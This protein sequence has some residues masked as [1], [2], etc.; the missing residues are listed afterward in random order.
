MRFLGEMLQECEIS[1][2]KFIP[3]LKLFQGRQNTV[4]RS[5]PRVASSF[6][7][8]QKNQ[9]IKKEGMLPP[10]GHTPGSPPLSGR[11]THFMK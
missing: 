4:A 2:L 8:I 6:V 10:A 9:K 11:P 5:L 7:L 1:L 3:F